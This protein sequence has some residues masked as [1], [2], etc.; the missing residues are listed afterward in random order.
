MVKSANLH[1]LY[2]TTYILFYYIFHQTGKSHRSAYT[3]S[4]VLSFLR[5]S[6][7]MMIDAPIMIT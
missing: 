7:N 5:F 2:H 1:L 3:V 4:D 6:K